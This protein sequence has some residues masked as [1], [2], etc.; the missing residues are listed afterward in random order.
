MIVKDTLFFF[1][2]PPFLIRLQLI[3]ELTCFANVNLTLKLILNGQQ[4]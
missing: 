1:L 2:L 4:V 3:L